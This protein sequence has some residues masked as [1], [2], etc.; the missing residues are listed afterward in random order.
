MRICALVKYPPIQGGVS[1]QSY[2]LCRR[3]AERGH[4][5]TVVTNA[6]EVDPDYRIWLDAADLGLLQGEFAG[7]G[8]LEVRWTSDWNEHRWHHIPT[9]NPAQAKLTSLAIEAIRSGNCDLIVSYYLQP[10]GLAAASASR[11]TGVPYLTRH[12]G[13]DRYSLMKNPELRTSY[14]E[15][16]SA[17]DGV[18]TAGD[19]LAGLGVSKNRLIIGPDTAFMP[20]SFSPDGPRLE[21]NAVIE[22]LSKL[23]CPAIRNLAPLPAGAPLIGAYGKVGRS[24]GSYALLEAIKSAPLRE[25]VLVLMCGGILMDRITQA[26]AELGLGDR[27]WTLPFLPHWRVPEFIRACDVVTALEH[28]FPIPQH[29]PSLLTE[30]LACGSAALAS[31]EVYRKLPAP[32]RANAELTVVD[33]PS[34]LDQLRQ[35]LRAA[36]AAGTPPP[37]EAVGAVKQRARAELDRVIDEIESRWAGIAHAP[38]TNQA[39]GGQDAAMVALDLLSRYAPDLL[40]T[41]GPLAADWLSA[42][43]A[44]PA[45]DATTLLVRLVDLAVRQHWDDPAWQHVLAEADLLWLACDVESPTGTAQFTLPLGALPGNVASAAGWTD[46]GEAYQRCPLA[47]AMLRLRVY[48][49]P[50]LAAI[51]QRRA[52]VLSGRSAGPAPAD[53]PGTADGQAA[54][55]VVKEGSLEGKVIVVSPVVHTVL[56]ACDGTTGVAELAQSVALAPGRLAEL[57]AAL[58][59]AG[60]VRWVYYPAAG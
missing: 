47:C 6:A 59:G 22:R 48:P 1:A 28:D 55:V 15:V 40:Q 38:T 56:R 53:H 31:A 32:V 19:N 51:R 23:G 49:A 41:S 44:S 3:L 11:I 24:K 20:E 46:P 58:A 2:W 4:Q 52:A 18:I 9:G 33:N 36:L 50:T 54:V 43:A 42:I 34:D 10:Y 8:R 25:S 60:L 39:A 37:C 21:L 45:K 14:A 57:L 29:G 30:I 26:I 35:G 16:L 7:G 17:A 27:V 13:S 12:A 5:V